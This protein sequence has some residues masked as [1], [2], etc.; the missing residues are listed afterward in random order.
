MSVASTSQAI[1]HDVQKDDRKDIKTLGEDNVHVNGEDG[2][3][4]EEMEYKSVFMVVTHNKWLMIVE[5]FLINFYVSQ[6]FCRILRYFHYPYMG[7]LVM[8]M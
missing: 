3:S 4:G 1:G 7:L 5:V 8:M 6:L 2:E